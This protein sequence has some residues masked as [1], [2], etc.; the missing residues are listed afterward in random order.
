[1]LVMRTT[2]TPAN[3]VGK[4][5]SAQETVGL[6]TTLRL[7]WTHLGFMVFSHGLCLCRRQLTIF[8]PSPLFL[9]PRS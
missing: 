8:T 7:P 1:M 5:V 3:P 9:T 2:E 4:L 6:S